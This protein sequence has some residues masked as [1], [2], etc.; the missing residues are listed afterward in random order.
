MLRYDAILRSSVNAI[1]RFLCIEELIDALLCHL[2]SLYICARDL[3]E[4]LLPLRSVPR[5]SIIVTRPLFSLTYFIGEP[6]LAR[7]SIWSESN[8]LHSFPKST[9]SY[10]IISPQELQIISPFSSS[11]ITL[12]LPHSGHLTSVMHD[13]SI[14]VFLLFVSPHGK[15]AGFKKS[16][17]ER[18][19][20]RKHTHKLI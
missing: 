13:H 11:L 10:E 5:L 9:S 4:S 20:K 17:I 19:I 6:V 2:I 15:Q 7:S 14:L 1:E 12:V 3:L 18:E 8:D 16:R